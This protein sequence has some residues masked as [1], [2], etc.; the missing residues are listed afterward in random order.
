MVLVYSVLFLHY[1]IEIIAQSCAFFKQKQQ[2]QPR[3][4]SDHGIFVRGD[5][6]LGIDFT[7]GLSMQFAMGGAY[8]KAEVEAIVRHL[9]EP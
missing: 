2:S 7:G 1:I 9:G 3:G 5:K 4:K 6:A 8:D